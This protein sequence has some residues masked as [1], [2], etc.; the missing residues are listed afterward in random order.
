M[1]EGTRLGT[2]YVEVQPDFSRFQEI[3]GAKLSKA[4][5]P[6]FKKA[7]DTAGKEIAAGLSGRLGRD[8]GRAKNDMFGL[9]DAMK[10]VETQAR[11]ARGGVSPLTKDMFGISKAAARGGRDLR[12]VSSQLADYTERARRA[13][14][15]SRTFGDRIKGLGSKMRSLGGDL[16]KTASG[17]G[18]V[19]GMIS[20][21]NRNFMF[22]RNILRTLKWPALISSLGLLSQGLSALA[23]GAVATVSALGP[24]AG[25]L[26]AIP[27][28]ALAA[29]Q[30]IGVLKLATA[31]VAGAVKAALKVEM[32]GGR[33]AVDTLRKQEQATEQVADAKRNLMSVQRQA[34]YAQEDLTKA[35]KEATRQLQDMRLASEASQDSE[36]G[37]RI[38]LKE[39]RRELAKALRDPTAGGLDVSSAELAV[40]Q[41]RQQLEETRV[42]AKR[43]RADYAEAQKKGVEKM[44]E[45]VAAKRAEAEANRDIAGAQRDLAKA[46]RESDDAL[47]EQGSAATALQEKMAM[48]PPAARKFVR[49]LI[50][51]K[52]KL[53]QLR[54]SA[55]SGFF[56]GA[57]KGLRSALKNFGVLKGIVG[58]T[59]QALG[60]L[61]KRAGRKIGTAAWGR[62]LSTLGKTNTKVIERMG[63][64]GLNLADAFRNVLVAARPFIG[65]LSK[66]I[67]KFS[68]WVK[69]EAAAGRETGKLGAF[70]DDTRVTMERVWR[71]LR[72][73]GGAFFHIGQAARPLGN[74][75]L[76]SLGNAAEGW[77]KWTDS[78]EGKNALRK[79]FTDS[80]PAIFETGRLLRDAIKA[81]FELGTQPG[82]AKMLR[83]VRT[84]LLPA[85]TDLVSTMTG[86]FGEA[87]IG[88]LTNIVGLF[89]QISQAN[90]PLVFF[91]KGIGWL[92]GA[93]TDLLKNN[94]ALQVLVTGVVALMSAIKLA[95]LLGA[96]TGFR[97]LSNAILGTA[98]AYR[99][100]GAGQAFAEVSEKRGL[101]ATAMGRLG[102][103]TAGQMA[104]GFG[105]ALG[106]AVAALGI[107][108]IIMSATQGDWKQ[109][110]FQAGGALAGGIAGALIG[111]PMGAM[112]GGGVGSLLGGALSGLFDSSKKLAPVQERLREL[113]Q[114]SSKAMHEQARAADA[115]SAAQG[116]LKGANQRQKAASKSV[117]EAQHKYTA[118]VKKFGPES[119]DALEAARALARAEHREAEAA[120][121]ARKAHRLS[122]IELELFKSRTKRASDALGNQIP[123]LQGV[124]QRL[125]KK[126]RADKTNIEVQDRLEKKVNELRRAEQ[127]RDRI[128]EE[129]AQKVGPKWARSLQNMTAAQR[130]FGTHLNGLSKIV[131]GVEDSVGKARMG[132]G[133]F[134]TSIRTT[135][136]Q[137]AE[138]MR[139]LG[140]D[141]SGSFSDLAELVREAD[142]NISGNTITV[143]EQLGGKK[144]PKL[145]LKKMAHAGDAPGRQRGGP[146]PALANG[147][148]LASVVPGTS[149]GDRHTLALNGVPVA[150]VESREGIFVGNRNLMATMRAANSAVPRFQEGGFVKHLRRGGFAEP[151]LD[152]PTGA[153]RSL[154][155]AAIHK[156]YEGAKEYLDKHKGPQGAGGPLGSMK[157][158]GSVAD[159]PELQPGISAIVATILKRWPQLMITSTT[160]GGHA[161]NSLH[162]FGRAVD[163]GAD[164]GY[165]LDAAAW[166]REKLGRNLTEGIHN[167]NLSVKYGEE[168]PP[169]FWGPTVW[170]DHL[171][172]IHVGKRRGGL[173]RKLAKG[174]LIPGVMRKL[175]K[176][177]SI[178]HVWAEHN[179]ADGDWGGPTLPS[180]VVA[181]LAEAAG[182][183]EGID[184]P[185]VT[186]EQA[187]RGESGSGSK[188]SARPGATGVDPGG[189]KGLGLWMITTGFNDALIANLGGQTAM[190]NP[191]PNAAA[192]ARIFASSG[193]GAWYGT[194]SV[195]GS[196]L[197]Y[198][199]NYDIR[200]SLGGATFKEAL[201]G[202]AP[203]GGGAEETHPSKEQVPGTYNG[204]KAG[205]RITFGPIPK[206]P[207]KISDQ[208]N[209]WQGEAPKYRKAKAQAEAKG[210]PATAQAIGRNLEAIEQRL[211]ALRA[212]RTRVRLQEAK[213]ALSRRLKKAFGKFGGYEKL[214]EGAELD[215]NSG[216]QFA[217]QV[218]GLEP[219]SP[220]LPANASDAQ[221]EAAEKNY[222]AAFSSYVEGQE[223]PAYQGLLEK[224]ATWRNKILGAES[225]VAG[226][227]GRWE[228]Q[229]RDAVQQINHIKAFS[230]AVK[231]RIAEFR[232]KH[233]KEELP[234]WLKG[235]IAQ[236]DGML[237]EKL[238]ILEMK[239]TQLRK[240]ISEARGLFFP[241]GENRLGPDK[242]GI[243]KIPL[244]G[245]GSFEEKLRDV[246]GIHWPDQHE[247]LGAAAIGGTRSPGRF[248]GVI[249]DL[250]ETIEGLGLKIRQAANGITGGGSGGGEGNSELA[251]LE[252]ELRVQAEKRTL[253]SELQRNTIDLFNKAYPLP[254]FAGIF[255]GGG[256]TPGPRTQETL[257]LL[258]GEE[259]VRPQRQED[260]LAETIQA[261]DRES[262]G[263]AGAGLVIERLTVHG[264]GSVTARV[265]GQEMRAI[266]K[267][268]VREE[269]SGRGL[270]TGRLR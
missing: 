245:S 155:Q 168:V 90:G 267:E 157:A 69:G 25:A 246:Q 177:G 126:W 119:R 118:A 113:S 193:L 3:L 252:H 36:K 225:S 170:A 85:L 269:V 22:F 196:N 13:A 261:L 158:S 258:T 57:T 51:M 116:R 223:R 162:Y 48:L 87:F 226:Y 45:V 121:E 127:S 207:E 149:T 96:V 228:A 128:L 197:H 138:R 35:R 89:D 54:A 234:A 161:T 219:Q 183:A 143:L 24:L 264:D 166:I 266:A 169:G 208:I 34:R 222:V 106:P 190:R 192:M 175:R 94:P 124:V 60:E 28:A 100:L 7:G 83:T 98:G 217:E 55:A 23:A 148:G 18:G 81:F 40:D 123:I 243:P 17:F 107:G 179:S 182:K 253:V 137:S 86:A 114:H 214:I 198:T 37:A 43:A 186:M 66:G 242:T 244:P 203:E 50:G 195:T 154:G 236:R 103:T 29:A 254:P 91:V 220:E 229:D 77:R 131:E 230:D 75:I 262:D 62:D 141:G 150:K 136:S 142:L 240:S 235:Q 82:A 251:D 12:S 184:V 139:E 64:A 120:K 111:G 42:D 270:A 49:V 27:A 112:I 160:G 92:A 153:L 47:N 213:K 63:G 61:A 238:P 59:S 188:N 97:R 79:Y 239:D 199:G 108:N 201:E 33:Q 32:Q 56:S 71:V 210:K 2:G 260:E 156:V 68:E 147:G 232:Q 16:R 122:G 135:A 117:T 231:Q 4:L 205:D 151:Q 132:F 15:S 212:Q 224:V 84:K 173:I 191:V 241:G 140:R 41:A 46:I 204:V 44:P 130:T 202:K 216:A 19:D 38:A 74:E 159:H 167:P 102:R 95:T 172:H 21:A 115:L 163:L 178:N 211:T 249:W 20:R 200:D 237:K 39:A 164:S 218:V 181:A 134:G 247:P 93:F 110:G 145:V 180:Y 1:A 233:G 227:E 146:V 165:M 70:F 268:V 104:L 10:R 185:G 14:L 53:D 125:T 30:A 26:V 171:D 259:R 263:N 248:G 250:Q 209:Y 129:A 65:W 144:L 88:L 72:G 58:E 76:I 221:R 5:A 80:K 176:G 256:V 174:G 133:R 215:Y 109:A 78:I 255:H 6:H 67:D 257:A 52:P 187:T 194:G 73:V 8:T 206:D 9:G 99:E 105:R 152:G 11:R 31:G 189:T 101:G 265:D